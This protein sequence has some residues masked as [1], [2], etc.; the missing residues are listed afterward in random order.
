SPRAR[1]SAPMR[2]E[3]GTEFRFMRFGSYSKFWVRTVCSPSIDYRHIMEERSPRRKAIP[4]SATPFRK[5][6]RYSRFG[7]G[8]QDSGGAMKNVWTIRR[9]GK[10]GWRKIRRA[11]RRRK[12]VSKRGGVMAERL[13]TLLWELRTAGGWSLGRLAGKA[14]VDKSALSRWEAGTRRPRVAELEAV[15]DALQASPDQRARLFA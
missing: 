2:V 1:V 5:G 3:V 14:G 6:Q 11:G 9:R 10:T 4:Q 13:G 12:V 7:N 8:R 15:L